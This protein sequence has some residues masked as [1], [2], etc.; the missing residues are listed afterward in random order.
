MHD[1]PFKAS[2]EIAEEN[3]VHKKD[4]VPEKESADDAFIVDA[5]GDDHIYCN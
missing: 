2:E 3:E 5:I 1:S 4:V